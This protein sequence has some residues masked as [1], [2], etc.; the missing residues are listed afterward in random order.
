VDVPGGV[1]TSGSP[2]RSRKETWS[3]SPKAAALSAGKTTTNSWLDAGEIADVEWKF[4]DAEL[5]DAGADLLGDGV[6]V[7]RF[8]DA[9][10]DGV[11]E[12]GLG[13]PRRRVEA[14]RRGPLTSISLGTGRVRNCPKHES[15]RVP[16]LR[17]RRRVLT[18]ARD[19]HGPCSQ[20]CSVA[21]RPAERTGL[22]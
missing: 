17:E 16:T 19:P 22:R 4:G 10:S 13:D 15:N 21:P 20:D 14:L 1:V 12:R 3:S 9:D 7:L 18:E 2:A 11:G 5:A 8:V 6:G